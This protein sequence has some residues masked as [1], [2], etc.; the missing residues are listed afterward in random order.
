MNI[1]WGTS[2]AIHGCDTYKQ[3]ALTGMTIKLRVRFKELSEEMRP[4]DE[5]ETEKVFGKLINL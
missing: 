5:K 2:S 4:L 1:M 3:V